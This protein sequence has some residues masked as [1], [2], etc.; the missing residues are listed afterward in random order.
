[1]D[2]KTYKENVE[3]DILLIKKYSKLVDYYFSKFNVGCETC[4]SKTEKQFYPIYNNLW[5]I[6]HSLPFKLNINI[7]ANY[8]IKKLII[9]FYTKFK[10]LPCKI[11]KTHYD[12]FLIN[13]PLRILKNNY[14]L[15]IWTLNLH[16]DV[17]RRLN[18]QLFNYNASKQKYT[19]LYI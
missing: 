3:N 4:Y 2:Q 16:N 17:N 1:M 14:D 12:K 10:A 5:D 19:N 13:R 7:S 15:Q 11:C 8:R 6:I 18:K 9:E